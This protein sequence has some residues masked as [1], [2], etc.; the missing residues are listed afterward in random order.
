MALT[1]ETAG[2]IVPGRKH[3]EV[4]MANRTIRVIR[5]FYRNGKLVQIGDVIEVSENHAKELISTNKAE[6]CDPPA[7]VDTSKKEEP[8][9]EASKVK[10]AT[11]ETKKGGK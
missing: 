1:V 11:A 10:D 4:F 8:K 7:K 2:A 5:K 3:Q 9:A 6:F